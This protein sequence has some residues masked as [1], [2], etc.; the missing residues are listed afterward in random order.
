MRA[1]PIG[2]VATA[3]ELHD[4]LA[5]LGADLLMQ[6]LDS[7]LDGTAVFAAGR[8]GREL[9]AGAVENRRRAR[10]DRARG[11]AR[12]AHPRLQPVAVAETC[13][14]GP[15]ALLAGAMAES[16]RGRRPAL[17]S[18]PWS[19]PAPGMDVRP[20]R[21]CCNLSVQLAGR[22]RHPA[23][24]FAHGRAVAGRVLGA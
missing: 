2:P 16:A 22:Q 18:A 6:T 11:S 9:C 3:G 8:R 12:P 7:I 14:D 24:E 4:S 1:V 10:L 17:S 13:L 19:P 23:A 20:A 5:Q 15:T 21:A